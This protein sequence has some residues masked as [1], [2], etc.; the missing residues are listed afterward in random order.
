VAYTPGQQFHSHTDWFESPLQATSEHGGNRKSSFF[1]Y[2]AADDITGGGTN[3]P[4]LDAPIDE[5][6]CKYVDCYEPWEAGVTFR[7]VVGNAVFW[8]NLDVNGIGDRRTVHAGLPP[9]SGLKIGM[10]IWTREGALSDKFRV[11]DYV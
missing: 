6:W 2:I 5:R 1:A 8:Y 9:M 3:F 4:L 10:N 11:I 7:P